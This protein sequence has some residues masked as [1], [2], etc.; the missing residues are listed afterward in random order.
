MALGEKLFEEFGQVTS[1]K[2]AK[3]HPFEVTRIEVS[4]TADI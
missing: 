4:F 1:T 2:V 3:V